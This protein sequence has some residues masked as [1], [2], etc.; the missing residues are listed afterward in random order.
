MRVSLRSWAITLIFGAVL[1]LV[2]CKKEAPESTEPER[3]SSI[4]ASSFWV[5][6]H[7]GGVYVLIKRP[8]KSDGNLYVGE[9]HYASGDLAYK[10][11]MT[12]F[13]ENSP[14]IDPAAKESF[15]GWDG[16]TLYLSQNRYLKIQE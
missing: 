16:D 10:G 7:D 1:G 11:P 4:P 6:G 8:E 9:I 2:G 14:E 3:P 5:G 12:L 13:P 15:E